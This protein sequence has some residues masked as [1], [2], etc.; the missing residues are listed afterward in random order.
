LRATPLPMLV[1]FIG[2][3]SSSP[4]ARSSIWSRRVLEEIEDEKFGKR[5]SLLLSEK[6][7]LVVLSLLLLFAAGLLFGLYKLFSLQENANQ[8]PA[9]THV[10]TEAGAN[11]RIRCPGNRTCL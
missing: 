4:S 8:S 10:S 5:A 6:G 3:P 2:R 1:G 7:M 11:A 9:H